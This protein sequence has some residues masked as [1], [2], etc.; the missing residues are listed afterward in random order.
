MN[1]FDLLKDLCIACDHDNFKKLFE[2]NNFYSDIESNDLIW[3]AI[4]NRNTEILFYLLK[5]G[6]G[7]S[8]EQIA[9]AV[10]YCPMEISLIKSLLEKEIDPMYNSIIISHYV[11]GGNDE[12]IEILLKKGADPNGLINGDGLIINKCKRLIDYCICYGGIS[13]CKLLLSSGADPS[14]D[15]SNCLSLAFQWACMNRNTSENIIKLLLNYGANP[16]VITKDDLAVLIKS[17]PKLSLINFLIEYGFD[18]TMINT[19]KFTSSA[20]DDVFVRL[21]EI[22]IDPVI[23]ARLCGN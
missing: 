8:G 14:L 17:N 13:T 1:S 22:G 7:I 4:T 18:L 9:R 21:L 3:T 5:R 20:K 19:L 23:L 16:L 2:I 11:R 6:F 15:N 10:C 12:V